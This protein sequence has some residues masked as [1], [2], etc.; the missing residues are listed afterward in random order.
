MGAI[1]S[2]IANYS[3]VIV[4]IG[5]R[6]ENENSARVGTFDKCLMVEEPYDV[7]ASNAVL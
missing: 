2:T 1:R 7:S 5:R 3:N 6:P 4:T